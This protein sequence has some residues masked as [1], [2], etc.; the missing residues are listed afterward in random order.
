MW[1]YTL[2][3]IRNG[4]FLFLRLCFFN[5]T[6]SKLKPYFFEVVHSLCIHKRQLV[7]EALLKLVF[8]VHFQTG[9]PVFTKTIWR[10]ILIHRQEIANVLDLDFTLILYGIQIR[11]SLIVKT[12]LCLQKMVGTWGLL[13]W[14]CWFEDVLSANSVTGI[15][16]MFMRIAA[17]YTTHGSLFAV[18][19]QVKLPP[20]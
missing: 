1:G 4:F 16:Q 13:T 20:V 3:G 11:I 9:L 2:F 18:A 19:A 7:Q 14:D 17:R 10:S 12:A 5:I 15:F 8:K 6:A